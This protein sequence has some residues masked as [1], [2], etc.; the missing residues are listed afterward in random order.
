[1]KYVILVKIFEA[2]I[3]YVIENYRQGFEDKLTTQ[4]KNINSVT[5][6]LSYSAMTEPHVW[7]E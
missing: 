4:T 3:S 2:N 6:S 7:V 1:M 5:L